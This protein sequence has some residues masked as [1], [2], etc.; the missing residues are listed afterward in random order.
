[1]TEAAVAH[2]A[3]AQAPSQV[4]AAHGR[5]RHRKRPPCSVPGCNSKSRYVCARPAGPDRLGGHMQSRDAIADDDGSGAYGGMEWFCKAHKCDHCRRVGD[6]VDV[7]GTGE[8]D[9]AGIA[10]MARA[11]LARLWQEYGTAVDQHIA[12][13]F[14][15]I[16]E[17]CGPDHG[18]VRICACGHPL[19]SHHVGSGRCADCPADS[20]CHAM[21]RRENGASQAAAPHAADSGAG[22]AESD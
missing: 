1:M 15:A 10:D 4:D 6:D 17:M 8:V 7:G 9:A 21:R 22:A 11:A 16:L 3:K 19:S 18:E 2:G 5:R 20:P 13:A 14:H 12:Y